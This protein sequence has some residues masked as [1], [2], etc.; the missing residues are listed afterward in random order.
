MVCQDWLDLAMIYAYWVCNTNIVGPVS[1]T[2]KGCV[3]GVGGLAAVAFLWRAEQLGL[4]GN[5]HLG[6]HSFGAFL[7]GPLN[8]RARGH[9]ASHF[10]AVACRYVTCMALGV[11]QKM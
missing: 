9:Q 10:F 6:I 8:R 11:Q 1:S 2:S 4:K 7:P 5:K 3:L